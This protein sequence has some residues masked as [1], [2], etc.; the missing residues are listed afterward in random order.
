MNRV[1]AKQLKQ[2]TGRILR[3]VRSGEKLAITYRGKPVAII[4]PTEP[5]EQESLNQIRPFEDAW[6][7]IENTLANSEP[8]FKGWREATDW[9]RGRSRR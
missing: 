5:D 9:V 8:R 7:D 3:R 2:N 4:S 1:S 6:R